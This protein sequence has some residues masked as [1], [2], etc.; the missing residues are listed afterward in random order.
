MAFPER[1]VVKRVEVDEDEK[2]AEP[3]QA[4][5]HLEDCQRSEIT[6]T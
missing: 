5:L 3:E 4:Q 1:K 2:L 6:C